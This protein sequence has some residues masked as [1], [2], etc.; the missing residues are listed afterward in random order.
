LQAI[1]RAGAELGEAISSGK[2]SPQLI[3]NRVGAVANA[4]GARGAGQL[5]SSI[6]SLISTATSAAS[7]NITTPAEIIKLANKTLG[8]VGQIGSALGDKSLSKTT[9]QISGVLTNSNNILNAV[10]KIDNATNVGQVLSG[11]S[12]AI[13][14]IN[15]IGATFGVSSKSSGLINLPG[16]Q[17][18]AAS[19]VNQALGK[20]DLP[21]LPGLK[22]V[23]N[24]TLTSTINNIPVNKGINVYSFGLKPEDHQPSGSLNMSR[25]D[26]A[27]LNMEVEGDGTNIADGKVTLQVYAVNYNVLRILSGMGGLAYSN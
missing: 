22:R 24:A 21:G 15:R 7:G 10:T 25:I 14:S 23:I 18:S 8:S 3:A 12:S 27:V 6:G 11:A 5:S 1:S 4:A 13:N 20:V 26:T 16:G 19:I 9:S 2:A 17:L